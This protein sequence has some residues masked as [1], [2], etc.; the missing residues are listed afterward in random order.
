M[1]KKGV[2]LLID[3][4]RDD[5]ELLEEVLKHLNIK[6]KILSFTDGRSALEYL[7]S[8]TDQPFLILSDINMPIMDGIELRKEVNADDVLRKKSIPF[9][10]LSTTATRETVNQAYEM[11]VQGFFQKPS[12]MKELTTLL[13]LICRYWEGCRHPNN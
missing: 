4:D 3:D 7:K 12:T 5:R 10:F 9:V 13:T 6:N 1:S 8:T 11:S 2:I